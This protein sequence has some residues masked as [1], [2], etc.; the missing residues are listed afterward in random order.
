MDTRLDALSSRIDDMEKSLT[1]ATQQLAQ[2]ANMVAANSPPSPAAVPAQND[3]VLAE[4]L[5][6]IEQQLA[7]IQHAP[8]ALSSPPAT[9]TVEAAP[10]PESKPAKPKHVK[11][12]YVASYAPRHASHH[13]RHVTVHHSARIAKGSPPGF[14]S[15]PAAK[16]G[17]ARW[18]LRA[19]TPNEAWVAPDAFSQDLRRIRVGDEFPGLGRVKSIRQSG[20]GWM[21]EGTAGN[22][23]S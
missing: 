14:L 5:G 7:E 19:A 11:T 18:V 6:K 12:T 8:P 10:V 1:H 23:R 17:S 3:S 2:V 4:R 22:V 13:A 20:D 15:A 21:V 16:A 9:E